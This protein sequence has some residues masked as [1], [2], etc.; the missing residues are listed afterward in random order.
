MAE[1]ATEHAPTNSPL[2]SLPAELQHQIYEYVLLP[3]QT[4]VKNVVQYPNTAIFQTC[5]RIYENCRHVLLTRFPRTHQMRI[6]PLTRQQINDILKSRHVICHC[7]STHQHPYFSPS[8]QENQDLLEATLKFI[9]SFN[10]RQLRHPKDKLTV[11]IDI[12]VERLT[13][14]KPDYPDYSYLI[15]FKRAKAVQVVFVLRSASSITWG[16][17]K[18]RV[19]EFIENLERWGGVVM[20]ESGG[21]AMDRKDFKFDD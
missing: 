10:N 5:K 8:W 1:Q 11:R 12:E 4:T 16:L 9:R 14:G 20:L 2:V 7:A 21:I 6:E 19:D 3:T 18:E 17:K 15:S 13:L